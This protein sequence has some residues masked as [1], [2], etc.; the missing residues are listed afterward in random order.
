MSAKLAGAALAVVAL[1]LAFMTFRPSEFP[2]TTLSAGGESSTIDQLRGTKPKLVLALIMPN[3]VM[4]KA[5][6]EKLKGEYVRLEGRATFAALMFADETQAAAF[7]KANELPFAVYSLTPQQHPV[8]YNE[9]VKTV[10]G[11][12]KRFFVGTVLVLDSKR[13]ITQQV[14][15]DELENL[16][17]VLQKL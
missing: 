9:V 3:D 12:R 14:N 10:G 8:E 4:S 2:N 15:G 17:A 7:E 6:V 1:G 5:A 13:K 11:F 16:G